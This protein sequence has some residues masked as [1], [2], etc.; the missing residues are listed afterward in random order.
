MTTTDILTLL[1]EIID[2]LDRYA[3]AEI[4]ADGRLI[5][6]AAMRLMGACEEAYTGIEGKGVTNDI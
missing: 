5:G 4:D 2:Y 1:D 3:D 6:N